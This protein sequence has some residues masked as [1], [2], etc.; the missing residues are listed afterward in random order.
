[1]G[2]INKKKLLKL[3]AEMDRLV[4]HKDRIFTKIDEEMYLL[5]KSNRTG[6]PTEDAQK[7]LGIF[8]I[9]ELLESFDDEKEIKE[10]LEVLNQTFASKE[11]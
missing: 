5:S 8:V 9:A 10:I 7:N 1:M 4:I 6:K 3:K 11:E 2:H